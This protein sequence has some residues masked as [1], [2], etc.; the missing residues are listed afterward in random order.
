LNL[1]LSQ[2]IPL[3]NP[4]DQGEEEIWD[5]VGGATERSRSPAPT[6]LA[7]V[8][9]AAQQATVGDEPRASTEGRRPELSSTTGAVE[10]GGAR[11]E[12]EASAEAG[13][14][15]IANVLGAPT[16]TVVRSSL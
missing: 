1:E 15:D 14:V 6:T 5:T 12:E 7:I 13:I 3:S 10:L 2:D 8:P 11:V 4:V 9:E 16:L